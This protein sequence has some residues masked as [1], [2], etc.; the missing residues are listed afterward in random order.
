MEEQ[1]RQLALLEDE[2]DLDVPELLADVPQEDFALCVVG[3]LITDKSYNFN[4][5]RTLLANIWKPGRGI[6]IEDRGDGLILFRFYHPLDLRQVVDGGPWSFDNNLLTLHELKPGEDIH[7]VPLFYST[8]WVHIY[9]LTAEFYSEIVGKMIGAWMGEFLEYDEFNKFTR[10]D[11]CMRI[12]VKIDIR[13]SLK[14]E[15]VIRK[16]SKEL[17]VKFKYERL[18]TFCYICGRIGHIDRFCE[19]RFRI[20]EDQIVK[21]WDKSLKAPPRRRV[22]EPS[23]RWLVNSPN[24]TVQGNETAGRQP[25]VDITQRRP[26]NLRALSLNLRASLENKE[27]DLTYGKAA[28]EE[29]QEAMVI[30]EDRKRRR[31]NGNAAMEVDKENSDAFL[32]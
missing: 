8:F 11:P 16:P 15:K 18:P 26:A 30:G 5:M 21:L 23:S 24:E 6:T 19:I 32:S 7:E 25:L 31:G 12:K 13:R 22:A 29:E 14:R 10:E 4:A 3:T 2:D 27:A 17:L 9:E 20:P 28:T 1:L